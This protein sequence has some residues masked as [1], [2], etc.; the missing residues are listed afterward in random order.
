MIDRRQFTRGATALMAP[1]LMESARAATDPGIT[2]DEILLG[3]SVDL[4]GPLKELG[5]EIS[6]GCQAYVN[7]L[8]RAGGIHG[9]KVRVI[10]LDDGY[11]VERTVENARRLMTQERVF[12][13]V[14]IMGTPNIAAIL[15]HVS[16]HGV[17]VFCPFTGADVV[18]SPAHPLVFNIR[19]SYADEASKLVQHV[20]TL[21]I[22]DIGVLV[23]NNSFGKDGLAGV[24]AAVRRDGLAL[25]PQAV[26]TIETDASDAAQATA[27]IARRN[28]R[29]VLMI[30]A[31]KPTME[32]VRAYRRMGQASSLYALSVM[33]TQATIGAL[34]SDGVGIVVTSVVPF[35]WSRSVP[36]S[37]SY[38]AAMREAGFDEL[39][40][41][42]FESYINATV[43]T[44]ALRQSGRRLTR[45]ALVTA[46][47]G[48]VGADFQGF[49]V[50]FGFGRRQGSRYVDLA[51]I[52]AN[53]RFMQ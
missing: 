10:T 12:A 22:K 38:Q 44:Q 52:S 18:R 49:R 45:A 26:V 8:N 39:S 42:S 27:R 20:R 21:G 1:T 48:L 9:R 28:P 13:L 40:F 50:D 35:P 24:E 7:A 4:S 36:L 41:L 31:G 46:M 19:A 53:G 17:P 23:Q 30:T 16:E 29:V 11:K 32:F 37:R 34:G 14:N 6:R 43:L 5:A 15:P 25:S 51:M 2:D 3:Q 33:G 47:E